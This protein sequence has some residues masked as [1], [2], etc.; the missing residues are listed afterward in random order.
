MKRTIIIHFDEL[1]DPNCI[2][3]HSNIAYFDKILTKLMK[4]TIATHFDK[5]RDQW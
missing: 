3:G 5:L 4:M 2:N 1:K